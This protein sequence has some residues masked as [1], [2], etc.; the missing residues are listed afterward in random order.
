[1]PFGARGTQRGRLWETKRGVLISKDMR[2]PSETRPATAEVH[3]T[4]RDTLPHTGPDAVT[5]PKILCVDD[6][7]YLLQGLCRILGLDFEVVT[8]G[9]AIAALKRLE[10]E[11]DFQVVLSDLK[12]PGLD[13]T[14]FLAETRRIV[15]AA[16]RLL[17]T[18]VPNLDAAIAAINQGGVFRFL[19][20]PWV[21]FTPPCNSTPCPGRRTSA[22]S[23]A[24]RAAE[25][26]SGRQA[27]RSR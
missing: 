7:P 25:Q 22:G 13:G 9:D 12:M 23:A 8:E 11:P 5:T 3:T 6:D 19:T 14:R 10:A 17:L 26:R 20:K 21:R 4:F 15:P 24:A 2:D 27:Y 18:G 16:T 1:M